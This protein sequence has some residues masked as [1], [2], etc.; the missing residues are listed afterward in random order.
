MSLCVVLLNIAWPQ[1]RFDARGG[2]YKDPLESF[3]NE[4]R[5]SDLNLEL[6]SVV[7]YPNG[8]TERLHVDNIRVLYGLRLSVVYNLTYIPW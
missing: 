8:L 7:Q 3:N 6:T 1:L 5:A 2:V 4:V